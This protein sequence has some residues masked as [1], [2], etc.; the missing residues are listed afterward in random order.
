MPETPEQR[1]IRDVAE[2]Q[3]R[4]LRARGERHTNW[5]AIS[6]LGVIGWS[7]VLPTLAGVALGVWID[8]RWPSRIPWTV[9]LLMLGLVVGCVSAWYRIREDK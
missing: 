4:M 9:T 6:I 2:R 3:R 7:V 8:Q 5:R 1:M